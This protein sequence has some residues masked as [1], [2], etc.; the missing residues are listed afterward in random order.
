VKVETI[1]DPEVRR[2]Q[3]TLERA[4]KWPESG[5]AE[6][7]RAVEDVANAKHAWAKRQLQVKSVEAGPHGGYYYV[8][9]QGAKVYVRQ[10]PGVE[11]VG[12][13]SKYPFVSGLPATAYMQEPKKR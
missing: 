12:H 13:V 4:Q 3:R 6:V 11:V 8:T 2:A 7:R 10:N 1:D 9:A 5:H